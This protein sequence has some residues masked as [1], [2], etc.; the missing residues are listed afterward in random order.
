MV[1]KIYAYTNKMPMKYKKISKAEMDKKIKAKAKPKTKPKIKF[2]VIAK[3]KPKKKTKAEIDAMVAKNNAKIKKDNNIKTGKARKLKKGEKLGPHGSGEGKYAHLEALYNFGEDRLLS[4]KQIKKRDKERDMSGEEFFKR[5]HGKSK[6][7]PFADMKRK[8][9]TEA[10]KH[11]TS[12]F[13]RPY[14]VY[15]PEVKQMRRD[16]KRTKNNKEL[17]KYRPQFKGLLAKVKKVSGMTEDRLD[18]FGY[19]WTAQQFKHADISFN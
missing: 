2:K 14:G 16:W 19:D 5:L 9:A 13:D 18:D 8:Q 3:A 7:D 1:I 12:T 6:G 10:K 4:Q 11:G 15:T 17:E